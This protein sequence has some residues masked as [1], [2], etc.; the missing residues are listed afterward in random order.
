MPKKILV[1]DDEEDLVQMIQ[2]RLEAAGYK[3]MTAPNGK[4]GLVTA[5][6]EKP[7]IIVLDLMMPGM[8][9]HEVA[10]ALKEDEMTKEIPII[11]FT[12]AVGRDLMK[13]V[14]N[15]GATDCVIKP[16]EPRDLVAK[17]EKIIGKAG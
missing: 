3:L 4:E 11:I 7:D 10:K 15:I 12:A 14:K 6:A 5:R 13:V 8:N 9:G 17:V 1:V 16:F 2:F